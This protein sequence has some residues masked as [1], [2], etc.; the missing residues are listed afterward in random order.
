MATATR[1]NRGNLQENS[2]A[3]TVR[4]A[5]CIRQEEGKVILT[6]EMPGVSK[7]QVDVRV[8]NDTLTIRGERE[9]AESEN[10]VVR[11]RRVAPYE[12]TYTLDDT[13]DRDNID[14]HMEHGLLTL[15]LNLKEQ[16][17][18]KRIEIQGS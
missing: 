10:Y 6:V 18:P 15:T 12:R 4:P 5:S 11:E 2:V 1:H 13:I 16:V 8:E 14:A 7:D 17:K 9:A 3:N